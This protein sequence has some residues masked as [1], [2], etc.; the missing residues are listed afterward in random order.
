MEREL[1]TALGNAESCGG[2]NAERLK[3]ANRLADLERKLL[4]EP[5]EFGFVKLNPKQMKAVQKEH[6]ALLE[7]HGDAIRQLG[8]AIAALQPDLP[9]VMTNGAPSLDVPTVRDGD[10]GR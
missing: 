7:T 5:G 3:A 1:K 8:D 2:D 9:I 4:G 6:Q 10:S